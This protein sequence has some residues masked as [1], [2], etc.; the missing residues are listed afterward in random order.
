MLWVVLYWTFLSLAILVLLWAML[1]DRPGRRGRPAARCRRCWYDLSEVGG[2]GS[3]S[4]AS[5]VVC[6]ECGKSHVSARSLRRTRRRYKVLVV[7][8]LLWALAYGARVTPAAQREGWLRAVPAPV[9]VLALPFLSEEPGSSMSFFFEKDMASPYEEA[10]LDHLSRDHGTIRV[11]ATRFG[12]LSRRMVFWMAR[13]ERVAV[14]TDASTAKGSVYRSIIDQLVD[15]DLATDS[16]RSWAGSCAHVEFTHPQG[17][18]GGAY[19]YGTFKIRRLLQGEYRI[20]MGFGGGLF[21]CY[22]TSG[23]SMSA[24]RVPREVEDTTP[25][26]IE[27]LSWDSVYRISEDGGM[28]S[29]AGLTR[30]GRPRAVDEGR[31]EAWVTMRFFDDLGDH[32]GT[33]RWEQTGGLSKRLAYAIDE[34][35]APAI[36]SSVALRD[37]IEDGLRARLTVKYSRGQERWYPVVE[38]T[39]KRRGRGGEAS[40]VMF[41]GVVSVEVVD[42]GAGRDARGLAVLR[43]ELGIWR[44]GS[45]DGAMAGLIDDRLLQE[46]KAMPLPSGMDPAMFEAM[47]ERLSGRVKINAKTLDPLRHDGEMAF[48]GNGVNALGRGG[49]ALRV[50][51]SPGFTGRFEDWGGLTADLCYEGTLDFELEHWTAEELRLYVVSGMVPEHAMP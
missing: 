22:T 12:W 34:G 38:L 40:S 17:H 36:D 26:Y 5:P 49:K 29:A 43:S 11:G 8:L 42:A 15:A 46:M 19:M 27:H 44:W 6:T 23:V 50:R 24:A 33:E 3:V 9:L 47:R 1:W 14:I 30:L 31:G 18:P 39:P 21:R 51:V 13:R 10:I 7:A 2:I 32:G 16:E 25:Y 20:R 28:I 35:L 41:G 4:H 45:G 48:T 37:Q